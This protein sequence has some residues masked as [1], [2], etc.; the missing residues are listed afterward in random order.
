[1]FVSDSRRRADSTPLSVAFRLMLGE[2]RVVDIVSRRESGLVKKVQIV[3]N[4]MPVQF[5]DPRLGT[6]CEQET[7]AIGRVSSLRGIRARAATRAAW[8][9]FW[10]RIAWSKP[11]T[12]STVKAVAQVGSSG[13]EHPCRSHRPA[14]VLVETRDPRP[15]YQQE[16]AVGKQLPDLPEAATDMTASP[17]QF[18]LLMKIRCGIGSAASLAFRGPLGCDAN[19]LQ[20]LA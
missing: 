9:A 8:K 6:L 3:V 7:S 12:F 17:I 1:M 4:L 20:E 2:T 19:F 14:P 13:P 18:V 15:G 11:L 16:V 5:L 10:K